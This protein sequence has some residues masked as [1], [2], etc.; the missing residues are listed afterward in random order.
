MPAAARPDPTG[1]LRLDA[2]LR[3]SRG[4]LTGGLERFDLEHRSSGFE[5]GEPIPHV[6]FPGDG[7]VSTAPRRFHTAVRPGE[8]EGASRLVAGE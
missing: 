8:Q 6:D 1:N 2:R 7:L 5:T 4:R 3:I